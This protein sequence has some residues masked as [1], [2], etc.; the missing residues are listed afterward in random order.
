MRPPARLDELFSAAVQIDHRAKMQEHTCGRVFAGSERPGGWPS[1][2]PSLQ[3]M[4]RTPSASRGKHANR[5]E[6]PNRVGYV[7]RW[8]CTRGCGAEGHE[9][10]RRLDRRESITPGMQKC[11]T[12]S[13]FARRPMTA[14]QCRDARRLLRKTTYIQGCVRAKTRKGKTASVQNDVLTDLA[15][16]GG[17]KASVIP[18]AVRTEGVLSIT[19]DARVRRP[20]QVES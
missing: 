20:W 18:G 10:S 14:Q 16:R 15:A 1:Q 2:A 4:G 5:Q 6:G 11:K 9:T 3:E 7:K 8:A 17:L 12:A 13:G 19:T